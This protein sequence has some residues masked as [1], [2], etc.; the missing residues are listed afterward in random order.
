MTLKAGQGIKLLTPEMSGVVL[1][2]PAQQAIVPRLAQLIKWLR[3]CEEPAD[4]YEF[5]R[6]LFGDL[7]AV[8]E[9]R[10]QC[11][12]IIKRLRAGRSLP[13]DTPPVP[14]SSD[15]TQLDSWELEAFVYER[16]ARQL[17]TVGD[18]LAWRCFGY[19][20]R[21]ILV[22]SRNQSSGPMFG[23]PGYCTSCALE[24]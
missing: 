13:G 17:R 23:A 10:A 5:Q 14:A 18:G 1:T 6:H 19:D 7:Y 3:A 12:R 8:E 11:S 16:L 24:V 20:R 2:H 21:M 4:F 22:L 9:R 15:P